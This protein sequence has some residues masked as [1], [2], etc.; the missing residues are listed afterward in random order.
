MP[1]PYG[2]FIVG[3]T[4]GHAALWSGSAHTLRDLTPR[5]GAHT[6]AWAIAVNDTG[7]VVGSI[8][9]NGV[10][11]SVF[12]HHGHRYYLANLVTNLDGWSNLSAASVNNR[13]VITGSADRQG[14][15]RAV[16]LVPRFG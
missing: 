13:G 3:A 15:A 8:D 9:R 6:F 2:S 16:I 14:S 10:E 1:F 5:I 11:R 7:D 12:W 4:D